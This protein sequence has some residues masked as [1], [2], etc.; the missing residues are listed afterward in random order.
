MIHFSHSPVYSNNRTLEHHVLKITAIVGSIFFGNRKN[1]HPSSILLPQPCDAASPAPFPAPFPAPALLS[2][3]AVQRHAD[4]AS[5]IAY[6]RL[7]ATNTIEILRLWST[8]TGERPS[9][10]HRSWGAEHSTNVASA[11]QSWSL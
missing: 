11:L 2:F 3:S 1:R 10:P 6:S 4:T 9:P 8:R 5:A 7:V